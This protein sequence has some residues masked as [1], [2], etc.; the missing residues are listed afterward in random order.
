[1]AIT[2]YAGP[3]PSFPA[4][5]PTHILFSTFLR[6]HLF[7]VPPPDFTVTKITHDGTFHHDLKPRI[8]YSRRRLSGF[9]HPEHLDV[10]TRTYLSRDGNWG[11]DKTLS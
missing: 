2:S 11:K 9:D 7:A 3:P 10:S 8:A 6:E 4:R 1:M 5:T